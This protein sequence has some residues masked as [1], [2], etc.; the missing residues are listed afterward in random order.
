VACAAA[1]GLA[2]T[3]GPEARVV[4]SSAQTACTAKQKTQRAKALAAYR[5]AMPKQRAAYFRK[6][7]SKKQRAAYVKKQQARRKA[8]QKALAACKPKPK[9]TPTPTPT[10]PR[11]DVG[12]SASS[13]PAGQE[14]RWDFSVRNAGP[15][16]A[17]AVVGSVVLPVGATLVSAPAGCVGSG[18]VSCALGTLAAGAVRDLPFVVRPPASIGLLTLVATV[19]SST[20]DPTPSNNTAA[21]TMSVAPADVSLEKAVSHSERAVGRTATYTLTIR[22]AGP[23]TAAGMVVTDPLPA[24]AEYV[25]M[26]SEKMSCSGTGVITCGRGILAPGESATATVVVRL[27]TAGTIVNTASL[28]SGTPDPSAANES[29]TAATNAVT[30]PPASTGPACAPT[31]ARGPIVSIGHPSTFTEGATDYSVFI[32][33]AGTVRALMLFVDFSDAPSSET[34]SAVYRR[35]APETSAWFT[36]ES[37]GRVSL[38]IDAHHTWLRMPHSSTS[39]GLST[40]AY[41]EQYVRDAV[42]VADAGVNFTPYELVYILPS[43]GAA[44]D[45]GQSPYVFGNGGLMTGERELRHVTYVGPSYREP[46]VLEHETLHQFGLPDLYDFDPAGG[47]ARHVGSWDIMSMP[48]AALFAWHEWKLGWIDAAA[49]RCLNSPGQVDETLTPVTLPGGVKSVVVPVDASRAY[50]VEAREPVGRDAAICDSGVLVY[51]VDATV[52]SGS[53]PIRLKAAQS[54]TDA[55]LLN[56]CGTLYNAPFDIGPGEVATFQEAGITVQ[57]L[58]SAPS[59][60]RV[61][62]TRT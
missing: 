43:A 26:A 7:R 6:H 33:P 30:L 11:A 37:D 48:V 19:S 1:L 22:N 36:E 58:L 28:R 54:A 50:V 44:I 60:Y 21:A 5:K 52:W 25:S 40:G 41:N 47:S 10:A 57:V 51:S 56:R 24:G 17:E 27:T 3:E 23:A 32:R 12:V 35:A 29:A 45:R 18:T 55:N 2:V 8:L 13:S 9:P 39:Y 16:G 59:G 34:T 20:A 53:G 31:L 62:V 46:W 14:L 49:I 4:A 38:Q 15:A 42:A 61:R